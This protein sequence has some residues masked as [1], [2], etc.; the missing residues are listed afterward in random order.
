LLSTILTSSI[1]FADI[2]TVEFNGAI[3]YAPTVL[4][5]QIFSGDAFRGIFSYDTN[6]IDNNHFDGLSRPGEYW[7][8]YTQVA[9]RIGSYEL[10]IPNA[11]QVSNLGI[12]HVS[13]DYDSGS[14][15]YNPDGISFQVGNIN[16][17][18]QQHALF[19]HEP[20]INGYHLHSLLL[21]FGNNDGTALNSSNLPSFFDPDKFTPSF[22][23][24]YFNSGDGQFE[25]GTPLPTIWGTA[26]ITKVTTVITPLS[27]VPLPGAVLLMGSG[28]LFLINR[29]WRFSAFKSAD[30][31]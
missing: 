21:G 6:A 10:S 7:D 4:A 22:V 27:Q 2:V 12:I 30:S 16:V 20:I 24:F 25:M 15:G 11:Q 29:N 19:G 23:G 18:G 28:L 3:Y 1:A 8:S 14:P 17:Q 13:N 5:P 26:S 9:L 31:L